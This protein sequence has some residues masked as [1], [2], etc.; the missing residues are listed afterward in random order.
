MRACVCAFIV[1]SSLASALS[2]MYGCPSHALVCYCF[3]LAGIPGESRLVAL[4][5]LTDD[6]LPDAVVAAQCP[7]TGSS[8][9]GLQQSR[10]LSDTT[11][12]SMRSVM[13]S[14]SC[15][16]GIPYRGFEECGRCGR[17]KGSNF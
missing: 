3:S 8:L 11:A 4:T 15:G 13:G 7:F 5:E 14:R 9:I 2:A 16:D 6:G 12:R 17:F 1:P 10:S